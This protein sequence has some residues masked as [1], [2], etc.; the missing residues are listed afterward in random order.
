[1]SKKN[2][3]IDVVFINFDNPNIGNRSVDEKGNIETGLMI[4]HSSTYIGDRKL[5]DQKP[6]IM[7][8]QVHMIKPKDFNTNY[9]SPCFVLYLPPLLSEEISKYVKRLEV[10]ND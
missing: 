5:P 2:P 1:M 9:F 8:L 7:Q 3:L 4:G 10:K 6:N